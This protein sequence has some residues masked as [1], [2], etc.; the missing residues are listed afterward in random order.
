MHR[1][2][3][4]NDYTSAGHKSH[5]LKNSKNSMGG[6][7]KKSKVLPSEVKNDILEPLPAKFKSYLISHSTN[8]YRLHGNVPNHTR[9]TVY[10][11]F[12]KPSNYGSILLCTDVAARG[13]DLPDVDWIVQYDTPTETIDY[14]HRIGRT[15]RKG[16]HGSS[17][18]FLMPNELPYVQLLS[19]HGLSSD[20]LS[21]QHVFLQTSE[22]Y[23]NYNSLVKTY[24]TSRVDEVSAVIIQKRMEAVAA[25]NNVLTRAG[26]QAFRSFVRA[27]STHTSDYVQPNSSNGDKPM[28]DYVQPFQ[29]YNL[30]LGHVAK[31]FALTEHPKNI[32]GTSSLQDDIIGQIFNCYFSKTEKP[33]E[34]VEKER[35]KELKLKKMGEYK[36]NRKEDKDEKDRSGK[37]KHKKASVFEQRIVSRDD[38]NQLLDESASNA[39]VELDGGSRG[40]GVLDANGNEIINVKQIIADKRKYQHSAINTG[41]PTTQKIRAITS[42]SANVT[43]VGRFHKQQAGITDKKQN[44][45]YNKTLSEFL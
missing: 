29:V 23:M 32:R 38:K 33:P 4:W 11:E 14:V 24:T 44:K 43:K 42:Q 26:K 7:D 3:E 21:L 40:K 13:L 17:L 9:Q 8:F 5:T 6:N 35:E 36:I 20:A 31:S 2:D 45:V 16:N 19:S 34:L 25:A 12:C 41:A 15:A 28:L 22:K 37:G 18:L 1:I 39:E 10:K 27:Y 30:H